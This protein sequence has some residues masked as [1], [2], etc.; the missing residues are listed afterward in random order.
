MTLVGAYALAW[1]VGFSALAVALAA[2]PVFFGG[3]DD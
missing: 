1:S 3:R 2:Y